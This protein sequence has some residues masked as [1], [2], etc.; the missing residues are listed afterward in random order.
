[1]V[2]TPAPIVER[3]LELARVTALDI[4]YDLGSGD[5]RIPILAALHYGAKAVGIE[6]Q[7]DL[8]EAARRR[9]SELRLENLVRISRGDILNTDLSAATVI[10]IYLLPEHMPQLARVLEPWLRNGG[11]IVSHDAEFPGW[12]PAQTASIP[13]DDGR[14][15]NLYL[16]LGV[17][18]AR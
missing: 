18:A 11:R 4:V 8:V 17:K 9:V 6:L 3:M 2:P 16:Y 10:T 15:H 13:G 1:Y 7:P 14:V 5:G 12:R